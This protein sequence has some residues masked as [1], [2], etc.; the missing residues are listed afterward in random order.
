LTGVALA[1]FGFPAS[2]S[3]AT[4]CISRILEM[5]FGRRGGITDCD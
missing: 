3:R 5:I 2:F 1:V 4:A